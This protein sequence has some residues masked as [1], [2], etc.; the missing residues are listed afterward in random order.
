MPR[1]CPPPPPNA[2][3]RTY[4]AVDQIVE[5]NRVKS[6]QSRGTHLRAVIPVAES[7]G[8][9]LKG[10]GASGAIPGRLQSG[11]GGCES[12]CWRG[13]LLAVGNAIGAGVGVWECLWGR[14]RAGVFAGGGLT[15][16]PHCSSDSLGEREH[17]HGARR[18]GGGGVMLCR[19]CGLQPCAA[20]NAAQKGTQA[21]P[22][23]PLSGGGGHSA[24]HPTAACALSVAAPHGPRCH[25]VRQGGPMQPHT[26]CAPPPPG[27]RTHHHTPPARPHGPHSFEATP[28]PS[29][30]PAVHPLPSWPAGPVRA[31]LLCALPWDSVTTGRP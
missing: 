23:N 13:R 2:S 16:P 6:A 19:P 7:V 10:R 26:M 4:Q 18:F 3:L 8:L 24:L 25:R 14:V 22:H 1:Y 27:A 21:R 28:P 11:H 5:A 17:R 9:C 31:L 20:P 12:G 15:A 29:L 30:K